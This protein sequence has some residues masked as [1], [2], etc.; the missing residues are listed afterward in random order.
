MTYRVSIVGLSGIATGKAAPGPHESLGQ[1]L[2]YSHAAAY[3]AVPGTL[4][5]AVCDLRA[6]LIERFKAEW[7][8]IWP[9]VR[10]YTDYREML[11]R[12]S[13]DIVS[14]ATPDHAHAD[15]VT[16]ACR[17][18]VKG[19]YCEKPIATTLADADRMIAAA[20][21]AGISMTINH[22]RRWHSDYVAARQWVREGGIGDLLF[23]AVMLGGP[24]SMLF[25]NGTHIVDILDYFIDDGPEWVIAHL[26]AGF[27]RYGPAY[28][29]GGGHDPARD[30]DGIAVI[31]YKNGVRAVYK[32]IRNSAVLAEFDFHGT[33]G[34]LRLVNN[35]RGELELAEVFQ[36]DPNG[37][38]SGRP[39]P[40]AHYRAGLMQAA[41]EDLI[42]QMERGRET[43]SPPRSARRTLAILLAILQSHH[44]GGVKV[45]FPIQ[46]MANTVPVA[47]G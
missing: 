13:P 17:S 31:Q 12:E 32:G 45:S 2:P 19:I 36:V 11:A 27:E 20:S 14:V 41:V 39:L 15:I 16:E 33:A 26:G 6:D 23:G 44:L 3:A 4:V 30:P 5:V 47:R 42:G 1:T 9:E 43:L 40:R 35:R 8:G 24:R 18:G 7:G 21:A 10:G 38:L 46:D 34:R 29:G 25:R 28:T 22:T 37:L